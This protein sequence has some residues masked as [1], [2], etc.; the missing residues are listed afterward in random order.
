MFTS[1]SHLAPP[2]HTATRS[3]NQESA[4]WSPK[5]TWPNFSRRHS[6]FMG[7]SL[8]VI[9]N[10]RMMMTTMTDDDEHFEL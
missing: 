2:A 3:A 9:M 5:D 4:L 6:R 10:E 1:A 8:M 7:G